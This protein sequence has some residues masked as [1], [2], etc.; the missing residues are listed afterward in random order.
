MS[1]CFGKCGPTELCN[2][3][4]TTWHNVFLYVTKLC[5]ASLCSPV[6]YFDRSKP[7][8]PK[9]SERVLPLTRAPRQGRS[10]QPWYTVPGTLLK[11]QTAR[12]HLI[13]WCPPSPSAVH[14]LQCSWD[15]REGVLRLWGWLR[16]VGPHGGGAKGDLHPEHHS[17]LNS[18]T[19]ISIVCAT[20]LSHHWSTCLKYFRKN[21]VSQ[22]VGIRV[23]LCV[24]S[25]ARS[26]LCTYRLIV[27]HEAKEES[28]AVGKHQSNPHYFSLTIVIS[29]N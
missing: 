14:Q 9:E 15:L 19:T 26:H 12:P 7:D 27:F 29:Y 22:E 17:G 4:D 5:C 24:R 10:T 18:T 1:S 11:V 28:F 3:N 16:G 8:S 6:C 13:P 2:A 21:N 20:H 25:C 23:I